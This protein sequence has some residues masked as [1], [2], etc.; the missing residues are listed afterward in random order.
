MTF[1]ATLILYIILHIFQVK[2]ELER[3][4]SAMIR[5][6]QIQDKPKRGQVDQAAAKRFV[7]SGLWKP[8]ET[9]TQYSQI[10]DKHSNKR[11]SEGSPSDF[12]NKKPT[13][14]GKKAKR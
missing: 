6:K 1:K 5:L 10:K 8:G 12:P 11:F 2:S 9:K 14:G 13:S 7:A 4:K 3:V